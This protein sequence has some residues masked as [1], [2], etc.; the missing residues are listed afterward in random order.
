[1]IDPDDTG[2]S[3]VVWKGTVSVHAVSLSAVIMHISIYFTAGP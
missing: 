3:G 2:Q 1:M